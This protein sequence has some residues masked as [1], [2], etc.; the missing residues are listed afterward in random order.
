MIRSRAVTGWHEQAVT[1]SVEADGLVLDGIWQAGRERAAVIAPPHPLFG[2][3]FEH[4]VLYELAFALYKRGMASLRFNWRGAGGSQGVATGDPGSAERDYRAALDYVASSV[5]GPITGAGYSFGA[6]TALAVGLLDARL[7]DLLLVAPPLDM[8][9]KLDVARFEGPMHV[10]VGSQDALA[11]A[12]ALSRIFE[13]L[14]NARL[15]VIPKVDHFFA[16][17]G[18]AELGALVAAA[19]A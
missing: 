13:P 9:K 18:L 16:L 15:D 10:I 17:S 7:Q 14:A 5:A 1:V 19:S 12:E 8:L 3:S 6:V 11:P 4:P 2:G